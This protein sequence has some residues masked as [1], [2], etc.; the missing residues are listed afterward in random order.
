MEGR[1]EG[2]QGGRKI[3]Y[4]NRAENVDGFRRALY[5]IMDKAQQ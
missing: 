4:R 3:Q 5:S 1:R 2:G